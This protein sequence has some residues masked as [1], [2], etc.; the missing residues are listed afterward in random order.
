MHAY[1]VILLHLPTLSLPM[2]RSTQNDG[3]LQFLLP[4]GIFSK[5]SMSNMETT[6]SRAELGRVAT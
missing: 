3:L 5:N 4:V 6:D 2:D 1:K